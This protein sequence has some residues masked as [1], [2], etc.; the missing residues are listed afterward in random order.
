MLQSESHNYCCKEGMEHKP[1]FHVGLCIS[2]KNF[3]SLQLC[4]R[5]VIHINIF[6]LFHYVMFLQTLQ[7]HSDLPVCHDDVTLHGL[8]GR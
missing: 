7:Y 8:R 4:L 3:H 6:L 5:L 1:R 2:L